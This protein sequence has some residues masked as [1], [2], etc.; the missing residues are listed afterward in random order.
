MKYISNFEI[1]ELSIL[2]ACG[3]NLNCKYCQAAQSTNEYSKQLQIKSIEAL[4]DG[5]YLQNIKKVMKKLEVD[6]LNIQ[7]ISFWGQEPT[8]VLEYFTDNLAKLFEMCPNIN[9]F[10]T[11]TN[12]MAHMDKIINFLKTFDTLTKRQSFIF[13]QISYDGDYGTD[14]IRRGNSKIVYNNL[15][16][17]IKTLN[18]IYFKNL[19]ININVHGVISDEFINHFNNDYKKIEQYFIDSNEKIQILAD[20]NLNKNVFIKNTIDFSS[21]LPINTSSIDGIKWNNFINICQLINKNH[22]ENDFNDSIEGLLFIPRKAKRSLLEILHCSNLDEAL[23]KILSLSSEELSQ[24]N[25]NLSSLLYCGEKT[26][27]LKLLYNGTLANCQAAIFDTDP[28]YINTNDKIGSIKQFVASH[29][30]Y[31]NPLT[32]KEENIKNCCFLFETL[33]TSTFFYVYNQIVSLL[34][35]LR[36]VHQISTMFNNNKFLM[37][38]ALVLTATHFCFFNSLISTGSY[39]FRD[40]G[41]LRR[42][43]NGIIEKIVEEKNDNDVD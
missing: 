5:T 10:F 19:N 13:I 29:Y 17:L 15:E 32:D 11:S 24:Y 21:E 7:K 30:N 41:F 43:C 3:C 34:C 40:S 42:Y 26:G 1:E 4:K 20:L 27:S 14:Y 9:R 22:E 23:D 25:K 16:Y 33:S 38:T 12:G 39:F 35:N 36:E 18:T 2:G 28:Q 31:I 8:L 37:K 6:P